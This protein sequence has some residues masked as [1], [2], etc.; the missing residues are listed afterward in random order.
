M[1]TVTTFAAA[2]LLAATPARA[3]RPLYS[4]TPLGLV[5]TPQIC[6]GQHATPAGLGINNAGSVTGTYCVQKGTPQGEIRGFL[7]TLRGGAVDLGLPPGVTDPTTIVT[8][9]GI[10]ARGQIV[11]ELINSSVHDAFVWDSG[12][13]TIIAAGQAHAINDPGQI[14]GEVYSP[15]MQ[16]FLFSHRA[17]R[18]LGVDAAGAT[19]SRA[20][21][22]NDLGH[23]AG[24]ADIP[25][26]GP[27]SV[28]TVPILWTGTAWRVLGK[29]PTGDDYAL[30]T[31]INSF[32][33]IVGEAFSNN[34]PA[35]HAF[36]WKH[37]VYTVLP[38]L[39]ARYCLASSINDARV[40]V[41]GEVIWFGGQPYDLNT[42]IDPKD[43]LHGHV[44][45]ISGQTIN[46]NGEILGGG[47]YTSGPYSGRREI[48]VLSPEAQAAP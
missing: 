16:A 14:T 42:L 40:I 24:V 19:D 6:E 45:S 26:P 2:L 13:F 46:A 47:I 38:C 30:A 15:V 25:V 20:F 28:S 41:G 27:A 1:K 7:W 10:N 21:A 4:L 22:I 11:G 35:M 5:S 3:A 36:L 48:F 32:D 39:P 37:G 34:T 8:P 23:I 12:R 43:P 9:F 29:P 17:V 33:E 31:S 18:H 44:S